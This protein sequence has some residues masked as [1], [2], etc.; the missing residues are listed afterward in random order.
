VCSS[1]LGSESVILDGQGMFRDVILAQGDNL[2]EGITVKGGAP[3]SGPKSA[4]RIE[5]NNVILR[6]SRVVDNADYGVYLRSGNNILIERVF[7]QNNHLAIQHPS[8]AATNVVI[9]YNT[10]VNNS[11]GINILGGVPPRIENNII[12]GS[13]FC[14]IYEFNW[15]AYASGQL[16]RGFAVLEN[17]VFSGNAW[18]P[19]AYGSSTPPA[20]ENSAAGN[21][22]ADPQFNSDYSIPETSPAFER[23]AFLPV[24]LDAA[25]DRVSAIGVDY[26]I[27]RIL[28]GDAV[29]GYRV[30]Y[31]EG[32]IE[33]FY[34]DGTQ[35]LDTTPPEIIILSTASL[36]NQADFTLVYTID[37]DIPCLESRILVE[38]ENHLIVSA[39]DIF[40]NQAFQ[41]INVTLDTT[42]PTGE[43]RLN[44]GKNY[45]NI[46]TFV[47][48]LKASDFL[49]GMGDFR[50]SL[51]GGEVW[52]M[53]S[54]LE[55]YARSIYVSQSFPD[56]IERF[57][58]D[59]ENWHTW[60]ETDELAFR[61]AISISPYSL[62]EGAH[63][64]NVEYRD[65]AGNVSTV[66]Q[67][68]IV[69]DPTAPEG[70]FA[71]R[72]YPSSSYFYDFPVTLDLNAS[73]ALS[74]VDS[75]RFSLDGGNTWT[76]WENYQDARVFSLQEAKNLYDYYSTDT[77]FFTVEYKDL[78]GNVRQTSFSSTR[79]AEHPQGSI[80]IN[81][82]AQ[83][84]HDREAT[85]DLTAHDSISG[86]RGV[87]I[88]VL[89]DD[90]SVYSDT[91]L[92]L[93][94]SSRSV[95]LPEGDGTKAV[96]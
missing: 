65:Q 63:T 64:V 10:M 22:T 73:D 8:T 23:G 81:G 2:I 43:V 32:S 50:I 54:R 17:N 19:T 31:E 5:G 49:S 3:Y 96:Y 45:I 71:L 86:V 38:G 89:N 56:G 85:L 51:D 83:Y 60:D 48:E 15:N 12:T 90:G 92:I 58:Y 44:S 52:G 77:V 27:T 46:G 72:N 47:I 66:Y 41:S 7:F 82:G 25:L 37:G 70:S 91:G 18:R 36:T 87:Q 26:S 93:F 84:T 94:E 13:S 39:S 76:S 88:L 69:Y 59:M 20:V 62:T 40:G 24:G 11:I 14:A 75:M 95:T 78:A 34:N 33:E 6:N 9:R 61:Y 29:I 53:W 35:I 16:S 1:D 42:A 55:D 74:G 67:D 57:S 80:T 28:D 21:I 4:I 68:D 30:L 79:D